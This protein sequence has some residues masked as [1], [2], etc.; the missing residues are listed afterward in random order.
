[1]KTQFSKS[2][3]EFK[4]QVFPFFSII[5]FLFFNFC[6]S[7]SHLFSDAAATL[8]GL[9]SRVISGRTRKLKSKVK[10]KIYSNSIRMS[11]EGKN[12]WKSGNWRVMLDI[13]LW[14]NDRHAPLVGTSRSEE[15]AKKTENAAKKS[16]SSKLC[17]YVQSLLWRKVN[18]QINWKMQAKEIE[19]LN[20]PSSLAL[21]EVKGQQQAATLKQ[22][23]EYQAWKNN[24][25]QVDRY[26]C[27]VKRTVH[28]DLIHVTWGMF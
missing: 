5:L 19:F 8:R 11:R 24:Q 2:K 28:L 21:G 4:F 25:D 1:M 3:R 9:S 15:V 7:F 6:F 12:V 17:K 14:T 16:L 26:V 10:V 22:P 27:L 13:P 23:G 20:W 18:M